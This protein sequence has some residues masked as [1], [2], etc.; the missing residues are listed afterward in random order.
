MS[1][2]VALY[3]NQQLRSVSLQCFFRGKFSV[4]A[5]LAAI[6][7]EIGGR[8]PQLFVPNAQP[9]A[10][11][12][13]QPYELRGEQ[14][15]L[16][17]AL[18]QASYVSL[19]YPGHEKFL[20]NAIPLLQHVLGRFGVDLLE[21]V[22]Y[23]YD[24]A[25]GISR[26][27]D[28]GF[29]LDAVLDRACLPPWADAESFQTFELDLAGKWARGW[30]STQIALKADAVGVLKM[31]IATFV[32]PGV[33]TADLGDAAVAAHDEALATFEKM[34]SEKFRSYISGGEAE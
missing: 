16:R 6:Q 13:L 14:E 9:G 24:N 15:A 12:A 1:G 32:M 18:N 22:A 10:A 3:A 29:A 33:A 23:V 4:F 7:R 31:Q 2:Q 20:A 27:P 21:R 26:G 25:V 30:K 5:E 11:P 8:F 19:E 28:G 17:L 34:I